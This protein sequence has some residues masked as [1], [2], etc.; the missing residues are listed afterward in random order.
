MANP[1]Y[2]PYA[3]LA[4]DIVRPPRIAAIFALTALGANALVL[5]VIAVV[6][7]AG[8]MRG[9][10]ELS[11]D[12]FAAVGVMQLLPLVAA[13]VA[14]IVWL[15]Q[16]RT[17]ADVIDELPD[18]WGRPWIIFGWIVPI[19][20]FFVPRSIVSGVWRASAPPARSNWPVNAWWAAWLVYL[21]GSRVLGLQDSGGNGTV[22]L[23]VICEIGAIA[24]LLAMLVVWR[25]TGYQEAQAVRIREAIAAPPPGPQPA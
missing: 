16:A 1:P 14:V 4:P 17:T 23:P 7:A 5:N 18:T 11:E 15:W 22:L 20:S 8:M 19:I 2:Q 6:A 25:I 13:S 12:A 9:G 10:G 3:P 21:I 24:A